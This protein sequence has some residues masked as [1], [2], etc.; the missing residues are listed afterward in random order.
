LSG[1]EAGLP[2][3]V[4]DGGGVGAAGGCEAAVT[5]GRAGQRGEAGAQEPEKTLAAAERALAGLLT[6]PALTAAAKNAAIPAAQAKITRARKAI[7]RC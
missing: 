4:I 5:V 3:E 7:T 1:G 2:G 6:D